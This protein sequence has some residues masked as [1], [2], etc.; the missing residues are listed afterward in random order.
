M[1]RHAREMLTAVVVISLAAG[2]CWAGGPTAEVKWSQ[3]VVRAPLDPI[4]I[5][6]WD[7]PSMDP[8]PPI[9]AD[10]F[11]CEDPRPVIDVHWW[12][13]FPEIQMGAP[14]GQPDG[15]KITFW[16]DV[17]AGAMTWS[18]PGDP[19]HTVDVRQYTGD[20]AGY[21]VELDVYLLS[22]GEELIAV[23]EAFQ[24]NATFDPVDY[25]DQVPGTIY[26]I[27]IQAYFDSPEDANLWGW[28]TREH[29]WNDDAVRGSLV[30]PTGGGPEVLEWEPIIGL[31]EE[32]WDLAYELSVPEPTTMAMLSVA[33]VGVLVR[34]RRRRR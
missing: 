17:P 26:W 27:S 16:K 29:Y 14:V 2:A 19:I 23:D 30:T 24:Y 7:E 33:G 34:R 18:H 20:H 5:V 32:S 10:D 22:G 13:S 12:G 3:P 28:K 8:L 6:G 11:M 15:F 9:V 25:F 21:D 31:D 4:F 1:M